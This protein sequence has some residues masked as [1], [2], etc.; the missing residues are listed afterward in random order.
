M[1]RTATGPAYSPAFNDPLSKPARDNAG[2]AA[3]LTRFG[4]QIRDLSGE[5]QKATEGLR[6]EANRLYGARP[7]EVDRDTEAPRP[8]PHGAFDQIEHEI[9]DLGLAVSALR[10]QAAR[11]LT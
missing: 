1:S 4:E 3:K 6:Q 10:D 11:L 2:V 9:R 8:G 7:A 5:V